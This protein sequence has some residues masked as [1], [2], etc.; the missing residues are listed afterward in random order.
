MKAN[1]NPSPKE[2]RQFILLWALFASL[3]GGLLFWRHHPAG[4]RIAWMAAAIVG[5]LGLIVPPLARGFYRAW[6]AFAAGMNFLVTRMLLTL[7]FWVVL[8]P[9]ALFFKLLGR[10]TLELKKPGSKDSYW[11]DHDKIT[12]AASYRHLY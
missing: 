8:T 10:D 3:G 12:D 6:M 1:K 9:L 7:I 2:V 4:A 5:C 11:H